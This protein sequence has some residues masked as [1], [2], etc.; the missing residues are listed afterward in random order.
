M[1]GNIAPLNAWPVTVWID[2]EKSYE[3]T[4]VL[5][6]G[7]QESEALVFVIAH[8][9]RSGRWVS[10]EQIEWGAGPND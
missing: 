4:A 2:D 6:Q 7:V 8:N 5:A 9:T 10:S 1:S 3:G